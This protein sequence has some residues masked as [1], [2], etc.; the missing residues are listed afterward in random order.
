MQLRDTYT[1]PEPILVL[2]GL[3]YLVPA[4]YGFK[5]VYLRNSLL[6]LTLTTVGFHGTR[7]E[8]FFIID[9]IAIL[10][11][12]IICGWQYVSLLTNKEKHT[13]Y[14]AVIFAGYIHFVG[15]RYSIYNFDPNWNIKMFF[16]TL[17]HFFSAY[18]AHVTI[19]NLNNSSA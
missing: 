11:Y 16:H 13:F 19:C 4:Y 10:N 14:L 9:V 2:S 17:I 7:H 6:F 18:T 1:D 12:I 3:I 15:Q 8:Y 5:Y